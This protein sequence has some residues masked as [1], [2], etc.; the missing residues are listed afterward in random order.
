MNEDC[1]GSTD[2]VQ[3]VA[4]VLYLPVEVRGVTV[5]AD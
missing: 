3:S 1:S 2:L 5:N 4:I